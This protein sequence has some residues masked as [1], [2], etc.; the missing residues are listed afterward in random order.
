MVKETLRLRFTGGFLGIGVAL[1]ASLALGGCGGS[2]G[3]SRTG[4][5]GSGGSTGTGGAVGSGGSSSTG[6]STGTGGTDAGAQP[7]ASCTP[8]IDPTAASISTFTSGTDWSNLTGKWGAGTLTGSLYAYAGPNSG[9]WHAGVD[10]AGVLDIGQGGLT[11][12]PGD[13]AA[14]DYAGGGMMFGNGVCVDTSM[15][16]GVS[17]TLSGVNATCDVLFQFK[18]FDEQSNTNGGGCASNCYVFPQVKLV[19]GATQN[20]SD[21]TN[22]IVVHFTDA[23]GSGNPD[24]APIAMQ[25]V[26]LQWQLQASSPIGDAAQSGC[27]GAEL[28]IDNVM[29]VP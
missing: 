11:V 19:A 25:L 6:G 13:V 14:G 5:G 15:W 16:S 10:S 18:T 23:T 20:V 22:P 12:T 9:T 27:T 4:T 7:T 3:Q 26:G 2:T 28:Q 29:F 1:A 17:F 8:G 21:L 24:G